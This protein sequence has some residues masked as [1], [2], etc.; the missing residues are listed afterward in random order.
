MG[1]IG[2]MQKPASPP[3]RNTR[4]V[5]APALRAIKIIIIEITEEI[6]MALIVSL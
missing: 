2:V 3:K 6:V 5:E 1:M 4:P